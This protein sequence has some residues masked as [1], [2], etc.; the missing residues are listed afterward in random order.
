M[1]VLWAILLSLMLGCVK[2]CYPNEAPIHW[3]LLTLQLLCKWARPTCLWPGPASCCLYLYNSEVGVSVRLRL[4][5]QSTIITAPVKGHVFCSRAQP[6][7]RDC[8]RVVDTLRLVQITFS[9]NE[10]LG[11]S[12]SESLFIGENV[13]CCLKSCPLPLAFWSWMSSIQYWIS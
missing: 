9:T 8:L 10:D 1:T 3:L 4:H 11:F 2:T 13:I 12:T 6:H 7:G 5:A